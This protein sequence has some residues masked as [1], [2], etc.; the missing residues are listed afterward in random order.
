MAAL[1]LFVRAICAN[2]QMSFE[3]HEGILYARVPVSNPFD[4]FYRQQWG[5]RWDSLSAALRQPPQQ[6]RRPNVFSDFEATNEQNGEGT[7]PR[8][9]EGL[10]GYFV[11]DPGSVW[12]AE[13]LHVQPG[14]RVLDMCAAP[15]GKSL[16]L[17]EAACPTANQ[18]A[19]VILN[20]ISET[21][22]ERLKKV[23]QQ[24]VP[25]DRR[26]SVRISGKDGGLFAKSHPGHF[27]RILVDAPCSGERH[28]LEKPERLG[29]WTPASSR[30]LAQRQYALLTGA[31]L[32]AKPGAQ[33]VYSTCSLSKLE[34]DAVIE[35]L[36]KK[37]GDLF[38]VAPYEHAHGEKTS[39]GWQ[40]L[41]DQ[42]GLGPFYLS[43]LKRR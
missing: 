31:L 40:W 6:I 38:E 11:M 34:S 8:G 33:I 20:E 32:A 25:R 24:Y 13:A 28:L 12:I 16:V 15:G 1:A 22:R 30:R 27:D 2:K 29:E 21:R 5:E 10:L 18:D 17:I 43:V 3:I 7:I 41:P 4:E 35:K 37:K 14:D 19:E 23:I 39:F 26:E 9:S 36:L 42:C